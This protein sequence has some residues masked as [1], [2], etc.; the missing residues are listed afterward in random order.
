MA[1]EPDAAPLTSGS[2]VRRA[3][4]DL[5]TPTG[6]LLVSVVLVSLLPVTSSIRDPDFWWHLRAGQIILDTHALITTDPFTYTVSD[7]TWVMHEWLTEVLFAT[8]DRVGGLGLIV[9]VL[10]VVTWLGLLAVVA[11]ARLRGPMHG[12]VA[13]GMLAAVV[14]GYPIWGPRA[15]MITFALSCLVL[16]IAERHLVRGGRAIWV[17]PP[18]FLLWSNLHSGFIIGLVFMLLMAVGDLVGTALR[19]A[20]P[21]PRRRL[22]QLL[23]MAL[24]CAAVAAIN[25]NGPQIILYPF[26]TQASPAQQS[27]ILEWHSP[28]FHGWEVR[29]FAV[30]LVSLAALCAVNRRIRGRDALLVLATT[31]LSFQSVR[32]IALFVAAVTPIWIDQLNTALVAQ[33]A[34]PS[35]PVRPAPLGVR[36]TTLVLLG[37]GI[38]TLYVSSRLIPAMAIT[39]ASVTYARDFPVC[40]ARWLESAPPGLNIFN[41]YGEGGYLA[42]TV[43][44]HGDRIFVFGD[45]ALMGDQ[46]LITYGRV[47]SVQPEWEQILLDHHTDLVLFDTDAPLS[48]VIASSPRWVMVYSD[49]HNQAFAPR[50]RAAALHLPPQPPLSTDAGDTCVELQQHPT[51]DNG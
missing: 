30:L 23:G 17:L 14:T 34:R 9:L 16:W 33:R 48:R 38:L 44:Q 24:L 36:A 27:L 8:L 43:T 1:A 50:D 37:T 22:L 35:R 12:V 49:A 7:H 6:L 29:G 3:F 47:E 15:Q 39:P 31:A 11:R 18:L 40:A 26:A 10:S 20:D 41:Q 46:L 28:D 4:D 5:T 51:D 25:P 42:G 45:A 13:L 19:L 2:R 32:N 21:A